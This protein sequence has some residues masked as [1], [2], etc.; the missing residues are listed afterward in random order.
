MTIPLPLLILSLLLFFGRIGVKKPGRRLGAIGLFVF[1]DWAEAFSLRVDIAATGRMMG[2]FFATLVR[3]PA[4]HPPRCPPHLLPFT[5]FAFR[6]R[7][8]R[9]LHY[10]RYIIIII[11]L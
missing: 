4:T 8:L 3:K 10:S 2:L 9:S 5:N 7:D 6:E 1:L 11:C